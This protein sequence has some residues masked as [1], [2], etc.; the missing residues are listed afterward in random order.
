MNSLIIII[1]QYQDIVLT[2]SMHEIL[3][4]SISLAVGAK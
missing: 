2:C 1:Q 3:S 4:L